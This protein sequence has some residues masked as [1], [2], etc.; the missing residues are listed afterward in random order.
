M[1]LVGLDGRLERHNTMLKKNVFNAGLICSALVL[2]VASAVGS[3]EKRAKM[4]K[5]LL[6]DKHFQVEV[7]TQPASPL[8]QFGPRFDR[9]AMVGSIRLDGAEYLAEH[10]LSDEFGIEGAGV[11]N[12][13]QARASEC[14]VKIGVGML[15]KEDGRRYRFN[16]HYA[17]RELFPVSVE[18]DKY[19]NKI[20]VRQKSPIVGGY[21]YSYVK[22]YTVDTKKA[23]LTIE[24]ELTNTGKTEF[25][26][27]Q[28]NHNW[29]AFGGEPIGQSYFIKPAFE[30]RRGKCSWLGRRAGGLEILHTITRGYYFPS[31]VSSPA[32]KNSLTVTCR[33]SGMS[34]TVKGDFPVE[35]SAFFAEKSALCPEVFVQTNLAP[36]ESHRWKR[37]YLF[38]R[39][40]PKQK[41]K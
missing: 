9:T 1:C 11:L 25:T 20:T 23:T 40:L 29:F 41:G 39:L 27:D 2:L 34:V 14:F 16:K 21:G 10:G 36:G 30:V 33:K 15:V 3:A 35:R 24:Y 17:I 18:A 22:R 6:G 13:Q 4:E 8:D 37:T 28:Y 5:F 26:F 31:P 32:G 12:F 19:P 7:I 38:S